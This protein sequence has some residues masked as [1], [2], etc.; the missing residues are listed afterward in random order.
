MK[1]LN[2]K[3]AVLTFLL[4]SFSQVSIAD[5]FFASVYNGAKVVGKE[6]S[7]IGDVIYFDYKIVR[8]NKFA[9]VA[10]I[11]SELALY[12][13]QGWELVN[14]HMLNM[15]GLHTVVDYIFKRE[16]KINKI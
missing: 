1:N 4:I 13:D 15:N 7:T 14:T 9:A 12:G 2:I 16:K 5:G 6:V 3:G 8:I 10:D 11:E